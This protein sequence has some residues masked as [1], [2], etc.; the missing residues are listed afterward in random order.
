M[1]LI[2]VETVIEVCTLMRFASIVTGRQLWG[3][4]EKLAVCPPPEVKRKP[5]FAKC[6]PFYVRSAPN[7]G[8]IALIRLSLPP[9]SC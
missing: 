9:N 8:N 5:F 3:H 7:E 6:T 4:L 1:R 2:Y